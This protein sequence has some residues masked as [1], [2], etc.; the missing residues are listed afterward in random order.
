MASYWR[1]VVACILRAGHVCM[2]VSVWLRW[3]PQKSALLCPVTTTCVR[4]PATRS[5]LDCRSVALQFDLTC[6]CLWLSIR[7]VGRPLPLHP[8]PLRQLSSI[9]LLSFSRWNG[10]RVRLK[11]LLFY[12][13]ALRPRCSLLLVCC[14]RMSSPWRPMS[15][16]NILL[17]G[18]GYYCS[19]F[20]DRFPV[21]AIYWEISHHLF[22][23]FS[24]F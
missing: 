7:P 5:A 23:F 4:R 16:V 22:I 14:N 9:P 11:F 19:Y 21:P 17:R 20:D 18:H 10:A 13:T 2:C 3:T 6:R 8:L 24:F 15:A 1:C 12:R